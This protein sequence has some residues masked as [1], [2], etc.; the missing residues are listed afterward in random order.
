M[1]DRHSKTRLMVIDRS[2]TILNVAPVNQNHILTYLPYGFRHLRERQAVVLGF[3][4]ECQETAFGHYLL[5]N[6]YRAFNPVLMR[7]NSPDSWSPF[8]RGGFNGYLYSHAD[9]VNRID[10]SGHTSLGVGWLF[11][12]VGR[13]QS[14]SKGKGLPQLVEAPTVSKV[15]FPVSPL[16][17]SPD[18]V[19]THGS[20]DT[21]AAKLLGGLSPIFQNTASGLSSGKGFYVAPTKDMAADFAA[22]AASYALDDDP[23]SSAKPE[24]YSVFIYNFDAKVPGKDYRFGVMGEGGLVLRQLN[25]M[26]LLLREKMYGAVRIRR[27]ETTQRQTLPRATEAPF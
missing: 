8:G 5:G 27:G 18:F 14:T 13:R 21:Q 12:S 19:G 1:S 16:L 17:G 25:E 4:G 20:L 10:P 22:A 23:S 6:G 9:P 26:E 15:A 2:G 11:T 24:V 3:N 7:F